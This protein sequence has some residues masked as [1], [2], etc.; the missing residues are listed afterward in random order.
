MQSHGAGLAFDRK[1]GLTHVPTQQNSQTGAPVETRLTIDDGPILM[2][3]GDSD[4][5]M[6]ERKANDALNDVPKLRCFAFEEF[7]TRRNA[8]K[9]IADFDLRAHGTAAITDS[10]DNAMADLNLRTGRL[11]DGPAPNDEVAHPGDRSERLASEAKSANAKKVV[12]VGQ[13][14]GSMTRYGK[15]QLIC[16][17]AAAIVHDADELAAAFEQLDNNS[18][19]TRVDRVFHQFLNRASRTFEHF[20]GGDLID[21]FGWQGT[22]HRHRE[23]VGP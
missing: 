14:T 10:A 6:R 17:N 4:A 5:R 18:R 19:G 8:S 11:I 3:D 15:W 2:F 21:E 13:F 12:F 1:C 16:R 22:N 20:A 23:G 9:E 7:P